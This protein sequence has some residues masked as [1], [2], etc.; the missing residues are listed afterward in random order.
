MK[1]VIEQNMEEVL[2]EYKKSWRKGVMVEV[3]ES[4][5]SLAPLMEYECVKEASLIQSMSGML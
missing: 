4:G 1:L 2:Q 5:S 3:Q